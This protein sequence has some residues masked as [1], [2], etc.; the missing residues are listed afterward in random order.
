M[1]VYTNILCLDETVWIVVEGASALSKSPGILS[2]LR[3]SRMLGGCLSFVRFLCKH[4]GEG[5]D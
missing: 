1:P 5:V 3:F 2:L 4:R